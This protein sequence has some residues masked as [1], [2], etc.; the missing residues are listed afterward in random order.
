MYLNTKFSRVY[1]RLHPF[2]H[3]STTR[4][5]VFLILLPS[6]FQMTTT[7][8]VTHHDFLQFRGNIKIHN[9][10]HSQTQ[11]LFFVSLLSTS[12]SYFSPRQIFFEGT[13]M[14]PPHRFVL[15]PIYHPPT[16]IPPLSSHKY[17]LIYYFRGI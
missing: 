1:T 4:L 9:R 11:H 2:D 10:H 16:I 5:D 7:A 6:S 12:S 13:N 3:Q 8:T 17:Y 14:S 15:L